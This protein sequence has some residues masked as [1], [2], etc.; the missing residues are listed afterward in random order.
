MYKM[1]IFRRI[2]LAGAFMLFTALNGIAQSNPKVDTLLKNA[3]LDI[4]ENPGKVIKLGDSIYNDSKSTLNQRVDALMLISSAY[5]SRR[6]YQKSLKYF[7]IASDISKKA[8]NVQLQILVLSRT[9]VRYQQMKVYDKAIQCLDECDRLMKAN[10]SK[11]APTGFTMATNYLV[12]GLIYKEQLTCDIAIGYF[13]KGIEEYKKL[14]STVKQANLSIAYYNRGN[15]YVQLADYT[16]ANKSFTEAIN[17]AEEISANSLKAFAQKGLAEVYSHENNHEKAISVLHEALKISKDVGDLVLNR[18]LYLSLANNY[19]AINDLEKYEKYNKLFLEIQSVIKE[20]ERRSVGDSIEELKATEGQKLSTERTKYFS[21]IG[22]I[23]VLTLA[24]FFAL[25]KYQKR[26]IKSI[27][28]L[29]EEVSRIKT[30]LRNNN[31][32]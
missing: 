17:Y 9:A 11:D 19:L 24:S 5:S 4:Y 10:P 14:K 27:E 13:D 21:I 15:C 29:N 2:I 8:N 25:Y 30:G 28:M 31:V 12:R 32:T 20:S 3:K 23:F 7:M 6:D 1:F 16:A 18:E 22:V 26:S